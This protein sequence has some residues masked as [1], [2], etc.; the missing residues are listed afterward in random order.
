MVALEGSRKGASRTSATIIEVWDIENTTLVESFVVR[1]GSPADPL[2][3]PPPPSGIE[4]NASPAAAIAALVRARQ[5]TTEA[6]RRASMRSPFNDEI[7]PPPAPDVR[8]M[9]VG[10]DFGGFSS[11]HRSEFGDFV[12]DPVSS[13]N[14]AKGFVITGSEDRRL[15]LWDLGKAERTT[16]LSG[17]DSDHEKPNYRLV[18]FNPMLKCGN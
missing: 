16:V 15:R 18:S 3:D 12:M 9:V 14:A 17:L 13:R 1:V 2:P 8:A 10:I 7:V 11:S 6:E 5:S 4:A